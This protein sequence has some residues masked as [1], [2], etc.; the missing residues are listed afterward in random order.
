MIQPIHVLVLRA[1]LRCARHRRAAS[2]AA[3]AVRVDCSEADLDVALAKLAR[4]GLIH[5]TTD[6]RLT[7][8]GFAVA[9]ATIAPVRAARLERTR[10]AA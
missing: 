5:S 9:V 7:M 1:A 6:V 2:R 8:R 3:L 4:A 10:T